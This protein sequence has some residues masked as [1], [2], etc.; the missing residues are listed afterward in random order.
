MAPV[1][2]RN[3]ATIAVLTALTVLLSA[4]SQPSATENPIAT[5]PSSTAEND[6]EVVVEPSPTVVTTPTAAPT[7]EPTPSIADAELAD[8]IELSAGE[9]V[10]DASGNAVA[11]HSVT[12][13][14]LELVGSQVPV[15]DDRGDILTGDLAA[16]DISW[17]SGTDPGAGTVEFDLVDDLEQALTNAP[18]LDAAFAPVA[19]GFAL[20]DA[21]DCIRGWLAV[22]A[23]SPASNVARYLRSA[24]DQDGSTERVLF[25]WT[26]DVT[27]PDTDDALV[28]GQTVTFNNG[29]LIGTSVELLGWSELLDA[30]SPVAGARLVAVR[31][32]VCTETEDWPEFGLSVEGWNLIA[33]VDPRD[34]LGADPLAALTG[35]C[36]EGWL[37]FAA[38][39]GTAPS[40]FFISDGRD[41]IDGFALFSLAGAAVAPPDADS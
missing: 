28:I 3:R 27:E 39:L 38:P 22:S 4:C 30:E 34:R 29:P 10:I 7:P 6:N 40:G 36:T 20:P 25:Q 8:V 26:V 12:R 32:Q 19:P 24:T 18:G 31:L 14:P 16:L 41:P 15:F 23:S 1:S 5:E 21:G 37:E 2:A 35:V 13:L 11:V 9:R 33:P 17:C